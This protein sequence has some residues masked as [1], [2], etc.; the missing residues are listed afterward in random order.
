MDDS[1]FF[2]K[3]YDSSMKDY[4]M[5]LLKL[6]EEIV[7][8][9]IEMVN[10]QKYHTYLQ[11]TKWMNINQFSEKVMTWEYKWINRT[12]DFFSTLFEWLLPDTKSYKDPLTWI[13]IKKLEDV[14]LEDFNQRKESMKRIKQSV[15]AK[16]AESEKLKEDWQPQ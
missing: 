16:R 6:P 9:L 11:T 13:E 10:F 7:V 14:L 3:D 12:L 15:E 4:K 8:D 2:N 1:K 5:R